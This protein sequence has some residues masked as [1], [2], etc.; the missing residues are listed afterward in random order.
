MDS[1]EEKVSG[2]VSPDSA[3]TEDQIRD[4]IDGALVGAKK[5]RFLRFVMAALGSIPWVGGFIGASAALHAESEQGRMNELHHR[6]L[7][8][9][10]QKLHKLAEALGEILHR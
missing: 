9:H 3:I 10:K 4:Q 1:P 5:R 6:W 2:L 8:E 7:E